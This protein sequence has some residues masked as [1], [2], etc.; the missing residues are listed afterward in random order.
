MTEYQIKQLHEAIHN[1]SKEVL[2]DGVRYPVLI[3]PSNGCRYIDFEGVSFMEQNKAKNS[4][5]AVLAR[6]GHKITWGIR[7][8]GNWILCMDGEVKL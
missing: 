8:E 1:G 7:E 5:Y 2:I 4:R 6:R 3:Y